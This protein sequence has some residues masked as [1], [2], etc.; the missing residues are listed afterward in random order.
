[1]TQNFPF[2]GNLVLEFCCA[3][4]IPFG[5]EADRQRRLRDNPGSTFYCTSGHAMHY[6]GKSKADQ[7]AEQLSRERQRIA[8]MEDTI[9][10]VENQRALAARQAAA[11]KG[12][13]TKLKRRAAAGVCPCCNRSF[14]NLS[15]HMKS[16]HPTFAAEE[17]AA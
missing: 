10:F 3:C 7:L 16:K 4:G 9:A 1:M 11:A 17:V 5:I 2:T 12:Q 15:R 8:E 14:E 13:V 6:A